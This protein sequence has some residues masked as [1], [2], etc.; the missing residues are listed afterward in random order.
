MLL[1]NTSTRFGHVSVFIHWLVALAVYGMFA[2]G[3]WMV[4][5]SYYDTWYHQ[6]PE[7]HK[8][9]GSLIFF[10]MVIRLIWR[11]ISPPPKPLT[12]YSYLTRISSKLAHFTLYLALFGILGSGYLIS[13][14]DGQP[15]SVFGWF[16]IPATLSEQGIQADTA[17]I[18]HL[19]LAW[20]VVVLSLLHT[21]AAL[22]HH[23][24]DRDSTLKRIFGFN[25]D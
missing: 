4:T 8:S 13:T 5:L 2:L 18:I 6:A 11:F 12:S 16:N 3:L 7:L 25:P 19:Y 24:I 14:A 20:V 21:L 15:I 9:I 22:K 23:F 17:G 1:K 10:V